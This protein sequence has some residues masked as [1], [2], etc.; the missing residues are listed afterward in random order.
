MRWIAFVGVVGLT[1]CNLK[2]HRKEAGQTTSWEVASAAKVL[3]L[4]GTDS[5]CE[6]TKNADLE[7]VCTA[8]TDAE[9]KSIANDDVRAF[10]NYECVHIKDDGYRVMCGFQGHIKHCKGMEKYGEWFSLCESGLA[11][12]KQSDG[13]EPGYQRDEKT[14]VCGPI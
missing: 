4:R 14:A 9:C 1:A 5:Q 2:I 13:C 7:I 6:R 8:R 10:C 11:T 3:D 12:S